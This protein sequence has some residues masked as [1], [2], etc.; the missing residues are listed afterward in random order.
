MRVTGVCVLRRLLC[1]ELLRVWA[2]SRYVPP[3]RWCRLPGTHSPVCFVCR[4]PFPAPHSHAHTRAHTHTHTYTH[5]L[6]HPSLRA[7]AAVAHVDFDLHQG[8]IPPSGGKETVLFA[9]GAL[10][11]V[12]AALRSHDDRDVLL[13]GLEVLFQ[14]P[15]HAR[16]CVSVWR[17]PSL[18]LLAGG[19]WCGV[20][21]GLVLGHARASSLHACM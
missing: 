18:Y 14:V 21:V 3:E 19:F 5:S 4:A 20:Y 9:S 10:Q 13:H 2:G 1:Q 11:G 6:A 16:V 17:L 8:R 7:Q 15:N 12:L